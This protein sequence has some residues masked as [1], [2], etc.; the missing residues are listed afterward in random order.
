MSPEQRRRMMVEH[1]HRT[2]WVHWT[3]VM[4]GCWMLA[5]PFSF[6]YLNAERWVD[7]AGGR[8]PWFSGETLTSLR[9]WLSV[10]SDLAAGL[11]LVVFGWRSLR[12]GRPVSRWMCCFAG[13]WLT[14]APVVLWA[15][16]AAA[17]V[18]D[19]LVGALV[20]ALTVLVPGMPA[21]VLFMKMG[22]DTP[23]GWSYN[24]SSWP[25]RWIMIAAGFAGWL[26]SRYLA[27]FQLG[28]LA[29]AWDPFFGESTRRVLNSGMSHAWPISDAGLGTIAYTFEFLMGFMGSPARWRTMP[30]MVAFFGFLVIPLGLTHIVLVISQ[31][32]VVGH[33]CTFCL[34]AAAIMLPMIPLEVDEVLAMIQHVKQ[35]VRAG[36]GFWHVFWK[37]GSAEGSTED[38]RSPQMAAF[39]ERPWPVFLSSLR[40]VSSPWSLWAAVAL[41][42]AIMFVPTAFGVEPPGSNVFHVGGALAITVAVV[43]MSEPLRAGRWLNA[44][45]GIGIAALPW[46]IGDVALGAQVSG[47]VGGLALAALSVPRGQIRETYGAWDRWVV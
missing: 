43:A 11:V 27:M 12:P 40:G 41:G 35:R 8:G 36:E 20:I 25:Q 29:S 15:P 4:L 5:A 30:W 28:Y 2:L 32:V 33:W 42:L 47:V 34:L 26:V 46:A 10:W 44:A 14:F 6:G 16:T 38:E 23:R 22:G 39:A 1:H 19:T 13:I 9:A 21:M 18:N 17:Y 31:P 37:G 7:P 3:V 24:P 45:V